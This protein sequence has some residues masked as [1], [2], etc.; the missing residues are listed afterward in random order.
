MDLLLLCLI[1]LGSVLCGLIEME[2][3]RWHSTID[4]VRHQSK[5][6]VMYSKDKSL[7]NFQRARKNRQ[8]ANRKSK[9]RRR[10]TERDSKFDN[11][12]E[13]RVRFMKIAEFKDNRVAVV[14]G[15]LLLLLE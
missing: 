11:L 13:R 4:M 9:N 15:L 8:I 12:T 2:M 6:D 7:T 3:C 14:S 1:S 10:T 5:N